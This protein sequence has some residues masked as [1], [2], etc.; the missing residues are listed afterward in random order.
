MVG[1]PG[2]P[3]YQGKI[4]S[5]ISSGRGGGRDSTG[6]VF[7]RLSMPDQFVGTQKV[8]NFSLLIVLTLSLLI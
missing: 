1:G 7:D 6:Q 3:V 2:T 5:P 8:K 4:S